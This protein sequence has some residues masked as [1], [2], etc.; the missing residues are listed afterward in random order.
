MVQVSALDGQLND[1]LAHTGAVLF[2]L[3]IWG[4]VF[5]GTALFLGV[6]I[7]FV[8]GDSLLFGSGLVAASTGNINIVIL[9]IGTGIAAFLGDQVGFLLGRHYGR[10]YLERHGGR[11]IQAAIIKTETFY[12]QFG[13]WSVVIARFM[14]WARVFVP[15]VA[16]VG[17]MNYYKFLSSN[18]LGAL[19]WG[20]G[21]TLIGYYAATIPGVKNAAYIIAGVLIT[22]SVIVGFRTWRIDRAQRKADATA[23]DLED[24]PS[25][26]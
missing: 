16:G 26:S 24:S 10:G 5:A 21:L 18:L 15:V 9:V 17:R 7:P 13:W 14:P 25:A 22:A 6:F 20:V 2:Y 23:H 19:S 11:R 8:T 1:V 4:L 3:L 12:R